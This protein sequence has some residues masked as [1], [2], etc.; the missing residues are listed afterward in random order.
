V[1]F[2]GS[3]LVGLASYSKSDERE[4]RTKSLEKLVEVIASARKAESIQTLDEL[5]AAMDEVHD[6]MVR[7][8]ESNAL[9]QATLSAYQVSFEQTRAAIADR[10]AIL[11]SNPPRP[12][13]AVAS[14]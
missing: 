7:E 9:D 4:R 12:R 1:S 5:Q 2:L 3:G 6:E 8:V 10:R 11:M 13:A 14:A